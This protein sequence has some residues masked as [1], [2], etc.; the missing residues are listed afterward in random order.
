M[1]TWPLHTH[2][3]CLIIPDL[4]PLSLANHVFTD[5]S[6]CSGTGKVLGLLVPVN[7]NYNPTVLN[8]QDGIQ[9]N[10]TKPVLYLC[11]SACSVYLPWLCVCN[12][13]AKNCFYLFWG[14]ED[15]ESSL[16][17]YVALVADYFIWAV[18]IISGN[19]A[20]VKWSLRNSNQASAVPLYVNQ[21]RVCSCCSCEI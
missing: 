19:S 9:P 11:E 2:A 4:V 13:K 16:R 3:W 8:I 18:I 15:Y 21:Y 12:Y 7:G 20:A 14:D 1:D 17:V 10:I 5:V 6:L